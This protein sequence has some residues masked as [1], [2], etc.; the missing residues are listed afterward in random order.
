MK[1]GVE[2]AT[3]QN[4]ISVLVHYFTIYQWPTKVLY[5]RKVTLFVKSVKIHVPCPVRVRN[6]ITIALLK[7]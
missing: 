4:N 3:L 5:S 7:N 2:S 1:N 6:V